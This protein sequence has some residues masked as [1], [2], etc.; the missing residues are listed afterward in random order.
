[1]ILKKLSDLKYNEG[2]EIFK[3]YL[4]DDKMFVRI[5]TGARSDKKKHDLFFTLEFPADKMHDVKNNSGELCRGF[6]RDKSKYIFA[7]HIPKDVID[8]ERFLAR[9]N[10]P[11]KPEAIFI[12]RFFIKDLLDNKLDDYNAAILYKK[13]YP[14]L[15]LKASYKKGAKHEKTIKALKYSTRYDHEKKALISFYDLI[16]FVESEDE[17]P[18]KNKL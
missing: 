13:L 5:T 1:M 8:N 6:N 4:V 10:N 17:A 9:L 7:S 15:S 3:K 18:E 12:S 14:S 16:L 2:F 11:T